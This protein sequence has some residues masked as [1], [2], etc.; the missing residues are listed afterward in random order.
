[1]THGNLW[2][3]ITASCVLGIVVMLRAANHHSQG[4]M[5]VISYDYITDSVLLLV[6]M[7]A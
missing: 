3:C 6:L 1:M 4:W 5:T 7:L 2:L